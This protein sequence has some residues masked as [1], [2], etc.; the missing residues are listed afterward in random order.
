M[1]AIGSKSALVVLLLTAV[2]CG[3]M[4][5]QEAAIR[6][7]AEEQLMPLRTV[8]QGGDFALFYAGHEKAEVPVRV[9]AGDTIGFY[10]LDDGRL[11]AVAGPFKMDM[12]PTVREAYWK[13]LN[14]L[15]E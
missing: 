5:H 6:Y 13:R 7:S 11:K 1:F 14:Y 9:N 15:D 3:L 8:E 4:P 2:G 12:N 10:R